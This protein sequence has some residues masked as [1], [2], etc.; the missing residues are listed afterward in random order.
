MWG[1]IALSLFL[2]VPLEGMQF[3]WRWEGGMISTN[4][5]VIWGILGAL[6]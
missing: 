3:H 1:L 5:D 2:A 4:L 6:Y